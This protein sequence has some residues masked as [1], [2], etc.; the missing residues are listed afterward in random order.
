M[1]DHAGKLRHRDVIRRF[2]RTAPGFDAADF[3]HRRCFDGLIERLAPLVIAPAMILDLGCATGSGSRQLA[4]HYRKSRIISLDAS[5]AMLK[6]C[7]RKRSRFSR[8][9]EVQADAVRLPLL[10]GSIDL[11]F[12]NLLLPW[13]DE[14]PACMAEV[15]R[16]L[17]NGGVFAFSTLGS[18]S[19][20]ELRDAWSDGDSYLHVNDF[21]DM[22]DVGD[23][24]L[25]SGL[26][27]PVLDVDRLTVTFSDIDAM[28]RDLTACGARNAL[29]G[30]RQTLTGKD[31]FR[32]AERRL[33]RGSDS[34]QLSLQ[35]E[36]VFGHAWGT[37]PRPLEGELY[38]SPE[39]IGRRR[40]N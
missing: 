36:I 7:R 17:K 25:Q 16:V 40:R 27:E 13:I 33:L 34:G 22:H 14:L 37:G 32:D 2:D 10:T 29:S 19:L 24:L 12:A 28:L 9:R 35:L 23:A 39:S 8:L 38:V 18:G 20:A 15:A 5:A 3:V 1:A 4:R 31:R 30:R 26:A 6:I 21:A 11:V